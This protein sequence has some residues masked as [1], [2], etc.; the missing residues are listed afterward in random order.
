M[1]K[2]APELNPVIF[3]DANICMRERHRVGDRERER[4]PVNKSGQSG[5]DWRRDEF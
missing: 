3:F 4:E 1:T 5:V 2:L